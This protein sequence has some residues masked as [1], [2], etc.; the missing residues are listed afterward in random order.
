MEVIFPAAD[1]IRFRSG[2]RDLFPTL[3]ALLADVERQVGG[4]TA[5]SVQTAT[6]GKAEAS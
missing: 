3:F 4:D 2:R 1:D 6:A 5:K